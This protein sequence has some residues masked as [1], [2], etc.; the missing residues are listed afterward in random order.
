MPA[1]S[2]A[3]LGAA[4]AGGRRLR[5][6]PDR[7]RVRR[8]SR[9]SR[10]RAAAG[11]PAIA[12]GQHDDAE[13]R[14]AA[15][16]A[17]ASRVYAYRA[18]FEHGDRVLAA[19]IASLR[20][21]RGARRD[22][23]RPSPPNG[24]P[25]GS[26]ARE[27]GAAAAGLDA[28]LVGVGAELRYLTGYLAMPLERLTLLVIPAA[29]GRAGHADRP[30][31]RGDAGPDLRRG[32]RRRTSTVATWEETEDPMRL[33]AATLEAGLGRPAADVARG[34]RVGR[35]AR[36]L[37]A[38]AAARCCRARASRSRRRC[39]ARSGCARTRTRSSCCGGPPTPPTG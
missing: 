21:G 5:R 12:V 33:V 38:R 17:G 10:P 28:L 11:V 6:R 22:D 1:R 24:S 2:L 18:L 36:R 32:R 14:R 16:T 31:A 8:A 29:D 9:R 23:R 30:A 19:W 3:T 35:A 37:R 27:R 15:T 7:A 4:L 34:R 25:S 26:T 13:A 39:C 20:R